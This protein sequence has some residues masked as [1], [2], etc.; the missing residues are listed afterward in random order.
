MLT[1][2][3]GSAHFAGRCSNGPV[4][5]EQFA[6]Q[7]G[8]DAAPATQGGDNY[9]VGAAQAVDPG[10]PNSLGNQ[11]NVYLT[12]PTGGLLG[13]DPNALY[14]IWI[15]GNDV[16]EQPD[17]TEIPTRVDAVIQA[18]ED[19]HTSSGPGGSGAVNF[20]MPNLPDIGRTHGE[21]NLDAPGTSPPWGD[22]DRANLTALTN[23]WNAELASRLAGLPA[24]YSVFTLDVHALL[25]EAVADPA[26]FG[27]DPTAIAQSPG[28]VLYGVSCLVDAA[29][30]AASPVGGN[31]A[32][33]TLPAQFLLFDEIHPTV[34]GHAE[35]AARAVA[36]V[37]EPGRAWLLAAGL[38]LLAPGR[39]AMR[40]ETPV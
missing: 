7:I 6:A 3:C 18:M 30:G 36:A 21:F 20:L 27:L 26:A 35:I 23:A 4:W 9:S 14:T 15:G 19:L 37:P 34:T 25:E 1:R 38:A 28:G 24:G 29:C 33:G 8:H 40:Q 17:I 2:S 32:P 11:I 13:S 5:S 31:P 16:F 10:G 12:S 22:A 39:R